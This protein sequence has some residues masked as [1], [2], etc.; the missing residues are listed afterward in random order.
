[1]SSVVSVHLPPIFLR[2]WFGFVSILKQMLHKNINSWFQESSG[3]GADA[4]PSWISSWN[5]GEILSLL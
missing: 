2:I 4:G 3:G 5:F 1:M